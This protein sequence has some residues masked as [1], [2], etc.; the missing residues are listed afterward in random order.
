MTSL[1]QALYSEM[2][3]KGALVTGENGALAQKSAAVSEE[4]FY[5]LLSEV[6]L[7]M[8]K[9]TKES[10]YEKLTKVNV[11]LNQ[12]KN[13]KDLYTKY[14]TNFIKI[15]LF[16]REPRQGKGER[17][18]SYYI[19]QWMWE[20]NNN[21]GKF[22]I[23]Q[24]GNFGSYVDLCQLYYMSSNA[25]LKEYLVEV[26]GRQLIN[27]KT[28]EKTSLAGKWAPREQ[29]K[30]SDF[31]REITKKFF[32]KNK[33]A[34][35]Q[36]IVSLN[37]VLNVP[38]T[39]MCNKQWSLIDFGGV[40]SKAMTLYTKAFQDVE[41][42]A[43]P[44]NKRRLTRRHQ[45]HQK[46]RHTEEH[47]DFEDRERCRQNL[48]DHITAGKKIN[49]KV[50][51]LATIVNSYLSGKDED[52][53]WEAQWTTR[54]NEIKALI[55]ETG[56]Q[57]KILPMI[58]LSGSMSGDPMVNAITLGFFT[59]I[60]MDNEMD[61][62]PEYANM[63]LS[64]NSQPEIGKLP[65]SGSLFSK[66][67]SLRDEGWMNRWGGNTNVQSAFQMI[68][69]IAVKHNVAK[70]NMPDV[71]AIFSDMQFDQG[72]RSWSETSYEMMQRMFQEK[73]YTLPHIIF[74]N[75]RANTAGYQVKANQPN[76]TMLSG[77]STRMM[78]LFLTQP[79]DEL[80]NSL[81]MNTNANPTDKKSLEKATT[82]SLME[83]VYDHS[84]FEPINQSIINLFA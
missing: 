73:G 28:A 82:L 5:G 76:T 42:N 52:L 68:L 17:L 32:N 83:K 38:E 64:F 29:S 15:C 1:S 4:D 36:H 78:D 60:L 9:E 53:I 21:V 27:D 13:D 74:W 56:Y 79:I 54:I 18:I 65:R 37:K 47:P 16:M 55:K 58:D 34:Y 6:F 23:D 41:T 61:K 33:K 81:G 59:S 72:D 19:I 11:V 22:M 50:A 35:R 7:L 62:E 40:A 43:F 71:L 48:V 69:D 25:S 66:I 44:L 77:Y 84:M 2:A 8:R 63:F 10:V 24:L 20:N 75:L 26:Y 80:K 51:D 39:H 3:K 30:Y 12:I 49:A 31:A 46:R 67:K 57:P 14:F 45:L 70:E